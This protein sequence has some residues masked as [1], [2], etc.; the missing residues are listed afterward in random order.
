MSMQASMQVGLQQTWDWKSRGVS[1]ADAAI[2]LGRH[3]PDDW[4]VMVAIVAAE[5]IKALRI[6]ASRRSGEGA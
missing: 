2:S 4:Q 5:H 1:I 6:L 3:P